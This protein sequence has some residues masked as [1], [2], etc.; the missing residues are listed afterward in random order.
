MYTYEEVKEVLIFST[1]WT[2]RMVEIMRDYQ[3]NV[4]ETEESLFEELESVWSSLQSNLSD[5]AK[6]LMDEIQQ[7]EMFENNPMVEKVAELI[8]DA[9]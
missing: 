7:D 2:N 8:S 1:T 3:D 6:K 4:Y 9:I 5:G